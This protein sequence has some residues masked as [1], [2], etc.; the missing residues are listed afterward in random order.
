MKGVN[1]VKFNKHKNNCRLCCGTGTIQDQ[2]GKTYTCGDCN[3]T[4][5]QS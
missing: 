4:G 2:A 1:P 3:R 5:K